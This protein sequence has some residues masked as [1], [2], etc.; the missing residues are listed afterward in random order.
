MSVERCVGASAAEGI[1]RSLQELTSFGIP[2]K[3]LSRMLELLAEGMAERPPLEELVDLVATG[4]AGASATTRDTSVV[5]R[6]LFNNAQDSVVVIGYSVRQGQ[7][8]FQALAN[9][10]A[11]L[12]SLQVRMCLDIQREPGDTSAPSEVVLR[13]TGRFRRVHWPAGMR[14]PAIFYDPR[15]LG[16]QPHKRASLHAKC[17]IVDARDLFV[18]SANFTEAGQERNIEVGLLLQSPVLAHRLTRF[19]DTMVE[20]GHLK[21]AL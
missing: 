17:V 2:P 9:R 16:L 18:S 19:I 6:D 1:T 13:F 20:D 10:M 14:L 15:S 21:Q 8:V 7:H 4:P 12:P 3:G 11:E 5:V